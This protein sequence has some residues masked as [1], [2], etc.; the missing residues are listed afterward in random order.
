M[1]VPTLVFNEGGWCEALKTSYAPGVYQ[2]RTEEEYRAL[3]PFAVNARVLEPV[4]DVSTVIDGTLTVQGVT[5]SHAPTILALDNGG[6]AGKIFILETCQ[7]KA[8]LAA[9]AK[10]HGIEFHHKSGIE[11]IR[12][13]IKAAQ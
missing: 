12:A 3:A 11:K 10:E 2:P 7:D 9:Y 5:T 6:D 13:A 8:V 4:P 1:S